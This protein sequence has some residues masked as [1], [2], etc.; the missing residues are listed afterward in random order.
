MAEYEAREAVNAALTRR[1]KNRA[2]PEAAVVGHNSRTDEHAGLPA[3][4]PD[5]EAS[6]PY[7]VL[8]MRPLEIRGFK[9]QYAKQRGWRGQHVEHMHFLG[10]D[11]S[12]FG[13]MKGKGVVE[14][15]PELL[16]HY[17]VEPIKYDKALIDEARAIEE[18]RWNDKMK[19]NW[20]TPTASGAYISDRDRYRFYSDNCQDYAFRVLKTAGELARATGRKLF[21]DEP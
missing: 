15:D 17:E 2:A 19:K 14:D 9:D 18:K 20:N 13:E 8:G 7:Y 6:V 1:R 21:V 12:N 3:Y 4:R 11:G 5:P 10:S 16:R